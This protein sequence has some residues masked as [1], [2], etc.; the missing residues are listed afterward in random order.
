MHDFFQFYK[1]SNEHIFADL[2]EHPIIYNDVIEGNPPVDH[3][4]DSHWEPPMTMHIKSCPH[5]SITEY[6]IYFL[7]EDY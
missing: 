3:S 4:G 5:R 6:K 1:R 2:R 7:S